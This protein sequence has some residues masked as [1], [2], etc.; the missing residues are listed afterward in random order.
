MTNEIIYGA[1]IL[2]WP[3]LTLGVLTAIC[4]A[5]FC[6][7]R[8]ARQ[9]QNGV[10]ERAQGRMQEGAHYRPRDRMSESRAHHNHTG[11]FAG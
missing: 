6:D 10:A 7:A 8:N 4:W 1:Y 9:V 2:I 3:A 11:Q 5:V